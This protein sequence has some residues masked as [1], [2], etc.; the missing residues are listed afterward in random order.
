MHRMPARAVSQAPSAVPA[1]AGARGRAQR[2]QAGGL[3]F[4]VG[5]KGSDRPWGTT[6]IAL[7]TRGDPAP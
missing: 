4:G 2:L 7:H 5:S 1:V 6:Q 3:A